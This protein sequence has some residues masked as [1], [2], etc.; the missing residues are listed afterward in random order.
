MTVHGALSVMLDS[1]LCA[2]A[3]LACLTSFIPEMRAIP[4][5]SQV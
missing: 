5:E 4:D 3:P 1:I 2:L